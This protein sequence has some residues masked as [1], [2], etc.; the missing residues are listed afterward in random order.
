MMLIQK[1]N[2]LFSINDPIANIRLY[3]LAR[4]KVNSRYYLTFKSTFQAE[5]LKKLA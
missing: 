1:L 5:K 2:I 3:A 4:P